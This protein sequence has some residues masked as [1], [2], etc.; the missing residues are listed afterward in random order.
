MKKKLFIAECKRA[1]PPVFLSYA[2][3]YILALIGERVLMVYT[4][5]HEEPGTVHAVIDLCLAVWI[6]VSGFVFGGRTFS[7]EFKENHSLFLQT[8]PLGRAWIW[9]MLVSANLVVFTVAIAFL[10]AWRSSLLF[11]APKGVPF[12]VIG[13]FLVL[14]A[15]GACFSLIFSKAYVKYIAG[16][17]FALICLTAVFG[18][19]WYY[20][21]GPFWMGASRDVLGVDQILAYDPAFIKPAF[22]TYITVFLGYM[23][24]ALRF[25]VSAEVDLPKNKLRNLGT[26]LAFNLVLLAFLAFGLGPLLKVSDPWETKY[27]QISADGQYLMVL[28]KK[29]NYRAF[30]RIDLV[31]TKAGGIDASLSGQGYAAPVWTTKGDLLYVGSLFESPLQGLNFFQPGGDT[32][33]AARPDG[34][35]NKVPNLEPGTITNLTPVANG[36]MLVC[37]RGRNGGEVYSV[38]QKME[39]NKLL[40][41]PLDE[42]GRIFVDATWKNEVFAFFL[43]KVSKSSLWLIDP[44]VK[45]IKRSGQ[46]TRFSD[47]FIVNNSFFLSEGLAQKEMTRLY[48]G[49]EVTDPDAFGGYLLP[50]WPVHG[51]LE[52]DPIFYVLGS[53]PTRKA[54][55]FLLDRNNRKWGLIAT[56]ISIGL[57]ERAK[58]GKLDNLFRYP[59]DRKTG[60]VGYTIV[61]DQKWEACLFDT[62]INKQVSLGNCNSGDLP[63]IQR[64]PGT[65][66]LYVE[67][68]SG[69]VLRYVPGS[70]K[71]DKVNAFCSWYEL[72]Y[73]D[74]T[75]NQ[76]CTDSA[77]T[78]EFISSRGERRRLW[79]PQ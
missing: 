58:P 43:N 79:P 22:L 45:E 49:P 44:V 55:L 42:G 32:L 5:G 2:F 38:N 48:P 31:D 77:H 20:C 52:T 14:F 34:S 23:I 59:F 57:D 60:V 1:I 71:V 37:I 72:L 9:L 68:E 28:E 51:L 39:G 4:T 76:I 8:L 61:Q 40:Q 35:V 63:S 11:S 24:L 10:V 13:I 78:A 54:R 67:V 30:W 33:V 17:L 56:D 36:D 27:E 62:T 69:Q 26:V 66:D 64:L 41:A 47:P 25:L 74:E 65:S 19:T 21:S 12:I 53:V 6:I 29:K 73:L 15:E 3:V 75:G 7:T 16:F 18:Y 70:G 50:G 46:S